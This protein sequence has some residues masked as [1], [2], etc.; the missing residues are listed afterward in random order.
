[1][2]PVVCFAENVNLV[3]HCTTWRRTLKWAR[4]ATMDPE[5]VA[6]EKLRIGTWA[7]TQ[8]RSFSSDDSSSWKFVS[9]K[10]TLSLLWT[11]LSSPEMTG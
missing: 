10:S 4:V 11:L 6:P 1:M 3:R 9:P 8:P 7:A 2:R 5:E